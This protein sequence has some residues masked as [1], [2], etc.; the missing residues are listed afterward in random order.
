[1][2]ADEIRKLAESSREQSKT[3]SSS[4]KKI[5]DAMDRIT[6][7]TDTVLAQFEDID[8]RI[9][10]VAEREKGI[11][12]AMDEQGAGSKEILV[13]IGQ[14]NEITSQVKAGSAEM[15]TGSREIIK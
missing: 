7:S 6:G 12:N 5:K 14:L 3:V 10:A 2:V 13:A 15:L 8:S 4:L 1:V 11:L 9:Q